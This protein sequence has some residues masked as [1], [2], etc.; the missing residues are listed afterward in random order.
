[1]ESIQEIMGLM[2]FFPFNSCMKNMRPEKIGVL[3]KFYY[4]YLV[5]NPLFFL[6]INGDGEKCPKKETFQK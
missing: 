4:M 5:A 6:L 2:N 1:M 3:P